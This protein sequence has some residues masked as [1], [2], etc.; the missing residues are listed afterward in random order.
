MTKLK[1]LLGDSSAI[2]PA[3][4][5]RYDEPHDGK[6]NAQLNWLRAAVLGAN[7]GIVSVAALVV[8]VAGATNDRTVVLTAGIAGLIAGALS[9]A[10]GEYVSVSSQRDSEKAMLAREKAELEQFPDN[11]LK[12]LA[13]I[14]EQKGLSAKTA[15]TVA[16]EL[17]ANDAFAAHVDAELGIDPEDLTNPWHAAVAS[18]LS[19]TAGAIIPLSTII[20]FSTSLRVPATFVAVVVALAITGSLSAWVGRAPV[21]RATGRVVVGGLIAMAI[22]FA[23]GHIFRINGAI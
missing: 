14:Y 12:E 21:L 15:K 16:K 2:Y 6:N 20:L 19:F 9:M 5:H 10:A 23:V 11:E 3:K 7:D 4:F 22:T 13:Y 8:G 18:A 17:T 1:N